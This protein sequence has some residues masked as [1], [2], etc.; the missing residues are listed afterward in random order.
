MTVYF[1]GSTG[2]EGIDFE[3]FFCE[4]GKYPHVTIKKNVSEE[5]SFD[6]DGWIDID[7]TELNIERIIA[8]LCA[9]TNLPRKNIRI[10]WLGTVQSF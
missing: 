10:N 7:L 3:D 4:D 1:A 9:V 6:Q 5:I 2:P 8:A